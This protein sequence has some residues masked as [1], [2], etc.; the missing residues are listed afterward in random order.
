ML[1]LN[2]VFLVTSFSHTYICAYI[3]RVLCQNMVSKLDIGIAT[4]IFGLLLN[5]FWKRALQI[6]IYGN[7][8]MIHAPSADITWAMTHD[9]S[10]FHNTRKFM[11]STRS[12]TMTQTLTLSILN[13]NLNLNLSLVIKDGRLVSVGIS[14]KGEFC[15]LQQSQQTNT[16]GI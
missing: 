4:S 12:W 10:S 14:L 1:I 16:S 3:K 13:L 6:E 5:A 15:V 2:I 8:I 7:L 9:K 11:I